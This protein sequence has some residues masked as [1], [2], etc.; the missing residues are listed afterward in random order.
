[1][2]SL[3]WISFCELYGNVITFSG[4]S[5]DALKMSDLH[6]CIP[7]RGMVDSFNVSVA[8]GLLMHQAVCD[9]VS[10]MVISSSSFFSFL[11]KSITW[12]T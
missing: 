10:R 11:L 4:I 12:T 3:D 2:C 6:C 5:E 9:R 7:M 1:M 8:A